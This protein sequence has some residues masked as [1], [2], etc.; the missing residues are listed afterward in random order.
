V[1]TVVDGKDGLGIGT[2]YLMVASLA[3]IFSNYLIHIGLARWLEPGI[4]GIFGVMNALFIINRGFLGS[5]IPKATAKYIAE[6]RENAAAI[7]WLSVKLQLF[8]A[9]ILSSLF[10]IFSNKIA[11]SLKDES[12]SRNIILIGAMVIPLALLFLYFDGYLNGLRQFKSESLAKILYMFLRVVFVFLFVLL[13]LEI[14]GVLLGYFLAIIIAL[15]ISVAKFRIKMD[16]KKDY[17]KRRIINFCIPIMFL[18]FTWILVRNVNVLMIKSILGDN[19]AA[20]FY[21]AALALSDVPHIFFG[22][23]SITILPA[24]SESVSSGNITLTRKY[25]SESLRYLLMCLLP[26]TAIIS[27]TATNLVTLLYTSRYAPA[28]EAL[29]ILMFGTMFLIILLV[30]IAIMTGEGK[31]IYAMGFSLAA[32]VILIITSYTLIPKYGIQ[33]AAMSSAIASLA[34]LIGGALYVFFRFGILTKISSVIRVLLATAVIFVIA[35]LIPVAGMLLLP[36]YVLLFVLY[37]FLL[38]V[39]GEI[40]SEDKT[41]IK[42]ILKIVGIRNTMLNDD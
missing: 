39:F 5:G 6:S 12:L 26:I 32:L 25:I 33:G 10:I 16:W 37:L 30:L 2:I 1:R 28:G 13:G 29:S 34:G 17:P 42:K 15:I 35:V 4:Y 14:F 22:A 41:R 11:G 19:V 21:T 40:R 20:G 7:T 23:L 36:F 3:S 18:S 24:I 8:L 9:V 27:A 38:Y 31:P